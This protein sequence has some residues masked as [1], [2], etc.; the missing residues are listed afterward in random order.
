MPFSVEPIGVE[1]TTSTTSQPDSTTLRQP[2][3]VDSET[4]NRLLRRNRGVFA[5]SMEPKDIAV[6]ALD[7]FAVCSCA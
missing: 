7:V 1:W 3:V 2:G 4:G 6:F 5:N